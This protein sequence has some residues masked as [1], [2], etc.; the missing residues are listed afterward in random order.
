MGTSESWAQVRAAL[1]ALH[2]VAVLLMGLP[3]PEVGEDDVQDEAVQAWFTDA[4]A[5]LQRWGLPVTED[6]VQRWGVTWG[7]AYLAVLH[8]VDVP[9]NRYGRTFG[10]NQSWRMF[11][12]VP[13][14]SALWRL[15]VQEDGVW[16]DVGWSRFRT[17]RWRPSFVDQ[18]RVRAL[19][20][21]F[22][23]K[24]NRAAFKRVVRWLGPAVAEDFPGAT[25]ARIS[26]VEVSFPPPATIRETGDIVW[27]DTFWRTSLPLRGE[28]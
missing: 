10:V 25:A 12:G 18:E 20:N 17:P 5:T 3:E 4:T 23:Y 14:A 7:R 19:F 16:R 9:A 6:Q 24:R 1:V 27:G 2:L 15:E 22:T 13:R 26:F 8:T 21:Q 11:A 28:P